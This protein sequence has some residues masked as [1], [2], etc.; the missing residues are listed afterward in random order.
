MDPRAR[1]DRLRTLVASPRT[2]RIASAVALG[3]ILVVVLLV[4]RIPHSGLGESPVYRFP[5]HVDEYWHWGKAAATARQGTTAHH[6]PWSGAASGDTVMQGAFYHE[7]GFHVLLAVTHQVTGLDWIT[8]FAWGPAAALTVVAL[9]NYVLGKPH[10][11]G[12]EAALL[13]ALIPTSGRFLGPAFLVPITFSF[14]FLVMGMLVATRMDRW[15]AIPVLGLLAVTLWTMH[16]RA[17]AFFLLPGLLAAGLHVREDWRKAAVAGAVLLAPLVLAVPFFLDSAIY[18]TRGTDGLPI[19][20]DIW[21]NFGL[22]TVG[23]FLAGAAAV[24]LR[25]GRDRGPLVWTVS[26]AVAGALILARPLAGID[27]AGMY[28]RAHMLFFVTAAPVAGYGLS[29]IVEAG[30]RVGTPRVQATTRLTALLLAVLALSG[31]LAGHLSQDYY[32]L[33]D[34]EDYENFAWMDEHLPADADRVL[35]M[36]WRATVFGAYSHRHVIGAKAPGQPVSIDDVAI[37]F[38]NIDDGHNM[39][40]LHEHE[41]EV[42]YAPADVDV[43][44]PGITQIHP[45]VYLVPPP[46]S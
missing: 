34:K 35:M 37:Q 21:D 39:T 3:L 20:W 6:S 44:G 23:L 27:I 5:L 43:T 32:R 9:G 14:L 4:A 36:P 26:A 18:Q 13:T 16:A 46:P 40:L 17:A 15:R 30:R 29:R 25:R 33:L 45:R 12:H 38:F 8:I 10:G 28:S 1:A 2:R 42:I 7:V 11:F 19:I 24:A 31:G 22:A 41:V